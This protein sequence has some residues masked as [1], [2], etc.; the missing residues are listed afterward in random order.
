MTSSETTDPCCVGDAKAPKID[1]I[2]VTLSDSMFVLRVRVRNR[3]SD[4]I[5]F[6]VGIFCPLSGFSGSENFSENFPS[7][8]R[9]LLWVVHIDKV[10]AAV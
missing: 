7:R 4:R 2:D 10:D 5:P 8:F 3:N 9:T 1:P 6:S